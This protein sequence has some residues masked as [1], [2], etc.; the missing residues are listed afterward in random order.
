MA[1]S[2]G[3]NIYVFD[4]GEGEKC[5]RQTQIYNT[6]LD[7]WKVGREMPL[8]CSGGAAACSMRRSTCLVEKSKPR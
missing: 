7:E 6:K 2:F 4:G 8:S 1:V 5:T 3:L